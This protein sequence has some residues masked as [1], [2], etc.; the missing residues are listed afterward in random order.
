MTPHTEVIGLAL[1]I[2]GYEPLIQT[3][4]VYALLAFS[5]HIAV[6]AG[7]FS[8]AGVGFYGVGAYTAGALSVRGLAVPLAV[9]AAVA[10][11]AVLGFVLALILARLRNLY[12]AMAT[13]SFVL[14]VQVLALEWEDVTGGSLGLFGIPLGVS[15]TGLIVLT[16]LVAVAVAVAERGRSGRMLEALR[17][18]EQLAASLGIAVLR[19]RRIAFVL[20]AAVG[21]LAGALQALSSGLFTS[22]QVSFDLIVVALTI[23]VVGGSAAWYGPVIGAVFV[24]WL[25]EVLDVAGAYRPILQAALVLLIVIYAPGGAVA[26]IRRIRAALRRPGSTGDPTPAGP[27]RRD[28]D[29]ALELAR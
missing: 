3:S 2:S 20:S 7:L 25:P 22:E 16:V 18:D 15:T 12:L 19:A 17:L 21:G 26:L 4:L 8:L 29:S 10:V 23:L 28:D 13:F 14:L 11:S 5:V 27:D 1:S 24:V 6:R 9:L